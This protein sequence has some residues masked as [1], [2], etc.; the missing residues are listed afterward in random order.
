MSMSLCLRFSLSCGVLLG[1]ALGSVVQAAD[2]RFSLPSSSSPA[3]WDAESAKAGKGWRT[4]RD[5]RAHGSAYADATRSEANE[6][7]VLEFSFSCEQH[8]TFTVQPIWWLHGDRRPA[9][10]FPAPLPRSVGPKA[11]AAIGPELFFTAPAT[12]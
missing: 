10:R 8:A 3:V 5:D 4:T 9:R 2:S 6:P 1:L 11:I 12:R 7:P